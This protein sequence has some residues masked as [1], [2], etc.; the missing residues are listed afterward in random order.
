MPA[1]EI[2]LAFQ[3]LA[4]GDEFVLAN[5]N[6]E[7]LGKS[8]RELLDL[9]I[10]SS[11]AQEWTRARACCEAGKRVT[12]LEPEYRGKINVKLAVGVVNFYLATT[13]LGQEELE[14]ALDTYQQ[15]GKDLSFIAPLAGAASWLAVARV[16][17]A[18]NDPFGCLW[19]L[20]K[21][22]SLVEDETGDGGNS[23]RGLL[24]WESKRAQ[25]AI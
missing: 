22:W 23:L 17:R 18:R 13:M 24:D 10:A 20:Q 16:H 2:P 21:S 12:Q 3:M 7:Q 15:A 1:T 8:L 19:A 11:R 25:E 5:G 14:H 6:R 9:A 4:L